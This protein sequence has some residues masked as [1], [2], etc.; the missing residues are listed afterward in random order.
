M[1]RVVGRPRAGLAATSPSGGTSAGLQVRQCRVSSLA[2]PLAH[3][4]TL[5]WRQDFPKR[6]CMGKG[7]SEVGPKGVVLGRCV[8][9]CVAVLA[10]FGMYT[11]RSFCGLVWA[12]G[13]STLALTRVR[14]C[15]MV[16]PVAMG[17]AI[18]LGRWGSSPKTTCAGVAFSS[19]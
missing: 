7:P 15:S 11:G 5:I 18:S 6:C 2:R 3:S 8:Y 17:G 16:S 4:P 1:E 12:G 10:E 13:L 19:P 14:S 9:T